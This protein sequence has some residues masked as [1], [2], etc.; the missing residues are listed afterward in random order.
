MT[1]SAAPARTWHPGL[2]LLAAAT[3]FMENLDGTVLVTA[4]PSIASD[5]RVVPTD[6]NITM[7]AYLVTVA[8]FI[9][10]SAWLTE[11]FGDRNVFCTAIAIFT[12]A[13]LLCALSPDLTLLTLA[14]ILQGVGGALMVPV[15]RLV[16]LRSTE[17]KDLLRA[18]AFL[19]W[20]A[21]LAP[22]IAPL[23]GGLFT[24]YLTW[25]WIFLINVPL[26]VA[27]FIAAL[28]MVPAR[29]RT[30]PPAL[31]WFGLLTCSLGIGALVVGLE[32]I[33]DPRRVGIA[34]VVLL[35]AALATGAAVWWMRRTP[36]PL[37]DL[38][39]LQVRTFRVSNVGGFIYRTA[40]SAAPFLLPLLFQE[41][42]GWDP[43]RSG[44]M[45]A[46]VFIGN[47]GIK[48]ATTPL[49]R[50]LGFKAVLL[51]AVIGSAVTFIACALMPPSTPDVLIFV[52]LVCS[53]AFRSIGFTA[54]NSLQ[55]ADIDPAGLNSANALSS[56]ISQ[57]G[58]G[59]G[60]AAGALAL[61]LSAGL[62]DGGGAGTSLAFGPDPLMPYRIAFLAIAALILLCVMDTL[63]LPTGVASHVSGRNAGRTRAKE[64]GG[65]VSRGR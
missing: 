1:S 10:L 21:L 62:A 26:G 58:A 27:A 59:L 47:I 64:T 6:V 30:S 8:M 54:Y 16:V 49:I 41:G 7:T 37:F 11:R 20:P 25:H 2:A 13:S 15:G 12:G 61:R 18:I 14:R 34:V 45:V 22:V 51:L 39:A 63:R 5:F 29:A 36:K 17:K 65:S 42:Y 33:A 55:F 60:I 35:F 3:F 52:L 53:G 56:T 31:D 44:A 43:L 50:G 9:P 19:T 48:P 24:T 23:V 57:L 46:A 4:V 38:T 40:I 28:R 32:L